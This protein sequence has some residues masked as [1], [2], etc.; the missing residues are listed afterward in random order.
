M[1]KLN[2]PFS[3]TAVT[4]EKLHLLP[5]ERASNTYVKTLFQE[6]LQHVENRNHSLWKVQ[7]H[8]KTAVTECGEPH[9]LI[10]EITVAKYENPSTAH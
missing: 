10:S 4:F 2:P 9:Q 5:T 3:K 6:Q 8:Q 7:W 1:G